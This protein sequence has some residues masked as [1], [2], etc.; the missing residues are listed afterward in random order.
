MNRSKMILGAILLLAFA[1]GGAMTDVAA[2]GKKK[3]GKKGAP[4]PMPP[5]A[6]AVETDTFKDDLRVV[7]EAGLK[8][9]GPD[10]LEYFRKRTLKAPDPK[11]IK[12]LVK[13]LGDEDFNT[14]ES[15]F[16]TLVGM[17]SAALDGIKEGETDADLEIR[18]RCVDL[19][20]RI[21]TKAEPILQAAA[22]RVIAKLK[23]AG[24][25]DVLMAYLPF[26]SDAMVVDEIC[27]V[28]GSVAVR[29]G[30]AEPVLVKALEDKLPLKRAAAGEALAR[31]K[32]ADE[33]PNVKKLL[34]DPEV[35]VRYRVCL[36]MIPLHDK[37]IVP[38]M[39]D[40]LAEMSP[41]QLWP[42][43]EA[44][45]RLAG[46]KAP[47]VTLGAD[48]AARKNC[49]AAWAKWYATSAATLDMKKLSEENVYLG[50]TLIV[51]H[52]NRI[53]AGGGGNVG[54]IFEL[55]KDKNIRWKVS[56]PTGYPVDAHLVGGSRLI[57]AEYSA[58]K[59]SERDLKGDVKWEYFCG[60]NPFAVQRLPNGNTF[61]AMQ[62]RLI[63]VDRNKNE[64]WSYQRP[65]SDIIR[66]KKL[67]TGEVA[68]ITNQGINS[69]YIRMD[70]RTR[71]IN[72]QFQVTPVQMLFGSMDVLPNGNVLVTHYNNQRVHEYGKDGGLVGNPI[73]IAWPNSV[74]RLPN[75]NRLVTSYNQ[76]Q[77]YEFNGAQQVWSYP[78]GGI[79]FVARRR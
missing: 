66:A 52:N 17:G 63:E 7:R 42:I 69:Q 11:E 73:N 74:V 24:A 33:L 55:D 18:N 79:V 28:L 65:N 56:I 62:G 67:P 57:V 45:L 1:L 36:A 43:E 75:G 31:A 3:K 76:R 30:K 34:K 5:I 37:A 68:F 26:A 6:Q 35:S 32:F 38:V 47:N 78:T 12:A 48:A 19:K 51:Q 58:N 61:V 72:K 14:R 27:Q 46:D 77:V 29:D 13:Q 60:G 39:I 2:Q 71:Q 9:E 23:P 8:G 15:A 10:L 49:Q 4:Q 16:T 59:V 20:K 54:E 50:Y 21:D 25:A 40:L 44:L 22:A 70:A 53:G 64:V 41:N